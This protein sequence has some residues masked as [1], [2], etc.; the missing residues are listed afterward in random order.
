VTSTALTFT[1]TG[2][3][4]VLAANG[5]FYNITAIT[6]NRALPGI[7]V[8]VGTNPLATA[9]GDFSGAG[10]ANVMA[11]LNPELQPQIIYT[12]AGQSYYSTANGGSVVYNQQNGQPTTNFSITA[13]NPVQ[14]PNTG[15]WSFFTYNIP[16]TSVPNS[17][18][19]MNEFG[20]NVVGSRATA[21][22]F[23]FQLNYSMAG[24]PNNVSYM[25]SGG[26]GPWMVNAR[27]GFISEHGSKVTLIS[28]SQLIFNLAKSIDTL[29]FAVSGSSTVVTAT[30]ST[31]TTISTTTVTSPTTSTVTSTTSAPTT[32]VTL[33]SGIQIISCPGQTC[34]FSGQNYQCAAGCIATIGSIC[35]RGGVGITEICTPS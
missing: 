26:S 16:Q 23:F 3:S 25:S 33:S 35:N 32:V 18:S 14:N 15:L 13:A 5:N 29:R 12:T 8:A 27:A 34:A 1:G 2:A 30:T 22:P 24:T 11:L 31:S 17:L 10:N 4:S 6:L 19:Y 7:E 28:P 21:E 20:F 9:S